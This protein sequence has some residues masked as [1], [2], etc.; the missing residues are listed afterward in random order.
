MYHAL[1][2]GNSNAYPPQPNTG[3]LRSLVRF[4]LPSEGSPPVKS[5]TLRV[6]YLESSA[7]TG[8]P[9]SA[10]TVR[11][12]TQPWTESDVMW[13]NQPAMSVDEYGSVSISWDAQPGYRDF[14]VTALVQQWSTGALENDGM[15]LIGPE[16]SGSAATVF[17]LLARESAATDQPW[18]PELILKY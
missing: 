9:P 8:A 3:A 15:Y 6:Y 16:V 14:D 17:A 7:I 13:A 2:T 18:P 12:S 1:L 11:A 10:L 4:A 5:A